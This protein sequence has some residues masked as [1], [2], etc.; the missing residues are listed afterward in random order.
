MATTFGH[1]GI[2][3][4]DVELLASFYERV[5]GCVRSGPHRDLAGPALERGMG[6]A[7]ARV[8][9]V[10]LTLP[11]DVVPGAPA[12][13]EIFSLPDPV[14]VGRAVNR[15]GLMHLAFRVDDIES[16]WAA[17]LEA[18]G[19]RQGSIERV[20]VPGVGSADFV[21]AR[22]PEGNLIELQAWD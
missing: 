3:A 18:G 17:V 12:V 2:V 20:T 15:L 19:S 16:S 10:H 14:D 21:Y 11:G 4:R 7:G 5:L 22:D 9:G 13:L 8:R 1:V 6:L